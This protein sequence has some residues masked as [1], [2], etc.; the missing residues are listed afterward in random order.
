MC[1]GHTIQEVQFHQHSLVAFSREEI[2]QEGFESLHGHMANETIT[3]AFLLRTYVRTIIYC[4]RP[5]PRM[6]RRD[7]RTHILTTGAVERGVTAA[8]CSSTAH[9]YAAMGVK[10]YFWCISMSPKIA[11]SLLVAGLAVALYANSIPGEFVFDDHEAIENNMDVRSG[12]QHII[13][14]A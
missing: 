7:K 14:H 11:S 2:P 1:S 5:R 13:V 12:V 8:N 4:A 10:Y 3:W 6:V 9:E